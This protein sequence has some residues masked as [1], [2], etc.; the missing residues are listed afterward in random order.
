MN[1]K[2]YDVIVVGSGVGGSTVAR[3]MTRRGK[4]VLLLES[5]S[6]VDMLGSILTLPLMLRH[7][8]ITPSREGYFVNFAKTYGGASIIAAG[9]AFPA[10]KSM[11][12]PFGIDLTEETEEARKDLWI[13]KL[14]DRLIGSGNLRL[15]EAA[16][17]AGE[18]WGKMDNFIDPN[19][20]V[21]GCAD[22]MVGCKRGAK[23]TAR[24]FGDEA[25]K[26]GA[27]LKL[28]MTVK[29]VLTEGGKAVGVMTSK[30]EQFYGK[31]VVL[32]A[33][34]SN[35]YFLRDL[36]ISEA[37]RGFCCDWLQFVG[38]VV[39][40]INTTTKDNP[41][42]VGS[43]EHWEGDGFVLVP[44]MPNWLLFGGLLLFQPS[45]LGHFRDFWRMSG[46]MVKI[47][48][49]TQGELRGGTSFSKPITRQDQLKLDKGVKIIKKILRKAG[50][51]NNSF[52][53]LKPL[54]AHPS[55][56][57]RIGEVLDSNLETKIQNLYCCD[58]SVLPAAMGAQV[59]WT[60]AALGKRLAKHLAA[61]L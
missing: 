60:L 51:K 32:S 22:C 52:V 46:I 56:T 21:E 14:P 13:G 8:G 59:F 10:P 27:D 38:A 39:P 28:N 18:N 15:L 35:A 37:G 40:G 54:G 50:A 45:T 23:W 6:R 11:F 17:E 20:C 55:C 33:S 19:L 16:N 24:I 26:N 1:K 41:M 34:I 44:V 25:V 49:E 12:D 47:R 7:F 57:C 61:R 58:A 30:G 9:C 4:K 42:T 53:E 43:A 2:E 36:G 31:A 5:G 48:D 29:R 3:E